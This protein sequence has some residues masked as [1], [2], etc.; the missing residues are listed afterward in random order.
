MS[1]QVEEFAK[2]LDRFNSKR[3]PTNDDL[4]EDA[5]GLLQKYGKI[6]RDR[7]VQ[8]AAKSPG[9]RTSSRNRQSLEDTENEAQQVQMEGWLWCLMASLINLN[10]PA[11]HNEATEAQKTA[12]LDLHRYSTNFEIWQAFVGCDIFAQECQE[13][14]TWLHE[15]AAVSEPRIEEVVSSLTDKAQR[16]N[17]IWSAG[18]LFTKTAIKAQKRMRAWPKPL[19]PSDPGIRQSHIRR[20]DKR[21][22]A[23]QMDPDAYSREDSVLEEQDEFHE[24]AAC[25]T[26]WELLRRGM[27]LDEIRE[28]WLERKEPWRS[29]ALRANGANVSEINGGPWYRFINLATN[30][31]WAACCQFIAK[32]DIDMDPYQSAV[33][34]LL[35]GDLPSALSVCKTIDDNLFVHFNT[36]LIQRYHTFIREYNRNLE[37]RERSSFYPADANYDAVRKYLAFAQT[38]DEAKRELRTPHKAIEAA[39][40]SKDFDTFFVRQGQALSRLA[41]VDGLYNRLIPVTV[42]YQLDEWAQATVQNPDSLRMIV[43]LQLLLKALGML[44]K[45]YETNL[46]EMENNIAS[47]ISSLKSEGKF[48]LI[49]LYAS[50]LSAERAARV[51]GTVLIDVT[52]PKEKDF[53]SKLMTQYGISM[54][55]VL[56]AQFSIIN[57]RLIK[58][59]LNKSSALQPVAVTEYVGSG[60]VKHIGVRSQFIGDEL[61][62]EDE[63]AI[64]TIE[65]YRYTD[66]QNWGAACFAASALYKIFILKGQLAGAKA[67][68]LR[69]PLREISLAA[70]GMDLSGVDEGA[71]R[72]DEDGDV[73]MDDSIQED[74]ARPI[75]PGRKRKDQ[76]SNMHLLTSSSTSEEVLIAKSRSWR[77]L[78]QLATVLDLLEV[79]SWVAENL[80]K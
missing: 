65:W 17:G 69:A 58:P 79:W 54:P 13:I 19:E 21:P 22:V 59:L 1:R 28:W 5:E 50:Q 70:T 35:S 26:C 37:N 6:A 27:S 10:H 31:K 40:V 60:K 46:T 43:H 41:S 71:S 33:L 61:S 52:D 23:T 9:Q 53:Q 72:F 24:Q 2:C 16:G 18:W 57:I 47:Y 64:R 42:E 48:S 68:A 3:H 7:K 44:Q 11:R 80:E 49:P 67:L 74:K 77:Q 51:L 29:A 66:K 14:L 8:I 39:I 38:D 32:A 78:E 34:G 56:H 75:S 62:E 4:W 73:G 12:L 63:R 25:R 55:D 30:T 76:N 45:P 20:S 15:T 36:N